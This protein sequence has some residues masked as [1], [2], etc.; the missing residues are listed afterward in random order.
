MTTRPPW[1][2]L[3]VLAARKLLS[4]LVWARV[5]IREREQRFERHVLRPIVTQAERVGMQTFEYQKDFRS[6]K[7]GG[8]RIMDGRG[9]GGTHTGGVLGGIPPD[10]PQVGW[11]AQVGVS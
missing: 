2:A 3:R 1:I 11:R 10:S 5:C 8:S 6:E 4:R 9:E 7:H